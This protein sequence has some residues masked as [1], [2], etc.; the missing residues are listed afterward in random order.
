MRLR[1][2]FCNMTLQLCV[3]SQGARVMHFS[4]ISD[5]PS[6]PGTRLPPPLNRLCAEAENK[7][8]ST[9]KAGESISRRLW[10]CFPGL[11]GKEIKCCTAF[12]MDVFFQYFFSFFPLSGCFSFYFLS[13]SFQL[14]GRLK[15]LT[16]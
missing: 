7:Q 10:R 8:E 9:W 16:A 1:M 6:G 11:C 3:V 13:S 14:I 4:F 12:H 2:L 15:G 5:L